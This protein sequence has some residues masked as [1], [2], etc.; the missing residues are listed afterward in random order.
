MISAIMEARQVWMLKGS[1]DGYRDWRNYH[2]VELKKKRRIICC[3]MI[4]AMILVFCACGKESHRKTID[5]AV[6]NNILENDNND[7]D[8]TK[9]DEKIYKGEL[10]YSVTGINSDIKSVY[11]YSDSY[12]E[13]P[14]EDV[15]EHLRT[16]SLNLALAVTPAPSGEKNRYIVDLLTDIGFQDISCEDL[17]IES[18]KDTIGSAISHKNI[19]GTEVIAVAI[20]GD[21]YEAEWASNMMIGKSGDEEGFLSA[22]GKV[23]DR[24]K[25]YQEKYHLKNVKIWICGY[26]RAGAVANLTGKYIIQHLSEFDIIDEDNIYVYT[27]EAPN[28]SVDDVVYDSIHNV[29]NVN[30]FIPCIPFEKWGL[31]SNGQKEYIG[32]EKY[33]TK[34]SVNILKDKK[35]KEESNL[36]NESEKISLTDFLSETADWLAETIDRENGA[37]GMSYVSKFIEISYKKSPNELKGMIDYYKLVGQS[38]I[39]DMSKT[40]WIRLILT[41]ALS[42]SAIR[43]DVIGEIVDIITTHMDIVKEEQGISFSEEE[44]EILKGS[45]LPLL[46]ILQPIISSDAPDF[47]HL[48]TLADNAYS[49]I[50][51]HITSINLELIQEEDSY[52][53]DEVITF[54]IEEMK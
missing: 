29:I 35:Q 13:N 51:A 22:S 19:N 23:I 50:S 42:G 47:T 28:S 25:K 7:I 34:K 54:P 49:I 2:M 53:T 31:Y 26:S 27:F 16:M 36:T 30:D 17:L 43:T 46:K 37:E 52:F 20:R 45:V 5:I 6:E 40:E 48:M 4:I 15:N 38:I 11:Y 18:T 12:F 10:S 9:M 32:K 21:G 33:I 8:E 44:Y 1:D 24:I 3:T 14:G 39:K 41:F